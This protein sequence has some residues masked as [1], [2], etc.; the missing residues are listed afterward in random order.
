M[1]DKF[2]TVRG[3]EMK[4]YN[5]NTLTSSMEDYL[6]MIYRSSLNK[7]Y[8]RINV[9]AQLLNV[10]DSSTTKMVQKLGELGFVNYEKYGI[11]T[12]TE[13]GIQLG[14]LLL[15]RHTV[16]EQFLSFIG[17]TEDALKQ[18][19]LIEHNINWE[20]LKNIQIL[21]DFINENKD[22]FVKYDN[23][24]KNYSIEKD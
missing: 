5:K 17:C 10:K 9:L 18:T 11:I 15:N 20:T 16:L 24:K 2:Y 4:N 23:Y 1:N 7:P 14:K 8:I 12:L 3:Y 21:Y 6:E 22:I 13:K 19:E